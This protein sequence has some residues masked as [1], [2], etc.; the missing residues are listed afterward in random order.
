MVLDVKNISVG[1]FDYLLP[2]DRIARYPVV[3][4]DHSKLLHYRDGKIAEYKFYDLPDLLEPGDLMVY[5]NTKVIQ[6]R[7]HF[8]KDT[9]AGIEIF[10]LE[11]YDPSDY[12]LVFQ[13]VRG[14][15]WQCLIGN[16][17]RWK[18]GPLQQSLLVK[19]RPVILAAHRFFEECFE[20]SMSHLV[21]F[22]WD[23]PQVSWADILE[24]FG[25]LPIPPYLGR[26][27]EESDKTAYQ[28]VYSKQDGSVAAPTAGLHFTREVLHRVA[29]RG[30]C[31]E[32]VTLHVGAG[33][34]QPVKSDNIGGH[35]MHRETIEVYRH[36]IM[37]L[38]SHLCHVAAVGTTSVRT[39]ESLY[40]IGCH[41][42][43]NPDDPDLVVDQWEPYDSCRN[44]PVEEAL[45]AIVGYLDRRHILSIHAATRII[46]VPSY[47]FRIVD[48][49]ITNFHQPHS[50]LLLL[51]SAFV[52]GDDWRRIY[53]YA[54]ANG[55]RFLS[56]GDSSLLERKQ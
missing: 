24:C 16:A 1:A 56:Y 55:F 35:P 53:G 8:R 52:G 6:A 32:E 48:K 19:G 41:I 42:L 28:T 13:S 7:L 3:P 10:C 23:D 21:R 20:D 51:V 54:L 18:S 30:V 36:T 14:C 27:T 11:P 44:V 22:E 46:I 2:D 47:K 43:D 4:R 38:L 9:G 25:Q 49:L 45:G 37:S 39:L 31:E 33:T 50:T 29:L 26:A 17:R 34:F 12:A 15:T 40:Y 5:N